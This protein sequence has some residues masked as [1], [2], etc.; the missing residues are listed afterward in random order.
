MKKK[1]ATA[2]RL[3]A[4]GASAPQ[5]GVTAA[6]VIVQKHPGGRPRTRINPIR[7]SLLFDSAEAKTVSLFALWRSYREGKQISQATALLEAMKESPLFKEWEAE[8]KREG[9][10]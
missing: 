3:A 6:G 2:D 9:K 4:V 7:L 10:K 8:C 1:T 5:G